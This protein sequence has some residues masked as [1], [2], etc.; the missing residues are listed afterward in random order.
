MPKFKSDASFL[1]LIGREPLIVLTYPFRFNMSSDQYRAA[2]EHAR[3]VSQDDEKT[4]RS[5]HGTSYMGPFV[6][7]DDMPVGIAC[8]FGTWVRFHLDPRSC[9]AFNL[10]PWDV[11]GNRPKREVTLWV[12]H[13]E[14]ERESSWTTGP[15]QWIKDSLFKRS[16]PTKQ[17][18][19]LRSSCQIREILQE[20]DDKDVDGY[21]GKDF[22]T[23]QPDLSRCVP[24]GNF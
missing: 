16:G 4:F 12:Q 18:P 8:P 22:Q 2:H 10:D 6:F 5:E 23:M 9:E 3:W 1:I 21:H 20:D 11:E 14:R 7:R 17:K 24:T 15:E 19:E 13:S